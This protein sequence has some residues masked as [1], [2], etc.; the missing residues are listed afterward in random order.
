MHPDNRRVRNVARP[1]GPDH[2]LDVRLDVGK[3]AELK[4]VAQF[5]HP[6]VGRI[7]LA[8]RL[9]LGG[10]VVAELAVGG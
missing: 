8:Q 6:L 4:T 10:I 3:L 2:V 5:Q 7:A 1:A 9:L